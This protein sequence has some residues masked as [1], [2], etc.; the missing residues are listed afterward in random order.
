MFQKKTNLKKIKFFSIIFLIAL[1]FHNF[2]LFENIYFIFK[3]NYEKR[4]ISNYGY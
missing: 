3:N 2:S 1:I 4:N